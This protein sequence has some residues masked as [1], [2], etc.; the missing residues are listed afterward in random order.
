MVTVSGPANAKPVSV[1]PVI[2]NAAAVVPWSSPALASRARVR[3]R[4]G[5]SPGSTAAPEPI[6]DAVMVWHD[7]LASAGLGPT[8]KANGSRKT[9]SAM[10]RMTRSPSISGGPPAPSANVAASRPTSRPAPGRQPPTPGSK[11]GK[12]PKSDFGD[13]LSQRIQEQVQRKIDERLERVFSEVDALADRVAERPEAITEK[14]DD[15]EI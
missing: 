7:T 9:T 4:F 6:P 11:P 8:S 3:T 2:V 5:G 1:T 14:L 10:R 13:R 12:R 15:K